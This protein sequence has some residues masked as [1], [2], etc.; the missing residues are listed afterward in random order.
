M[1]P[2]LTSTAPPL[3]NRWTRVEPQG[4]RLGSFV[5]LGEPEGLGEVAG[6]AGCELLRSDL[7]EALPVEGGHEPDSLLHNSVLRV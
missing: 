4:F 6:V 3:P 5:A 1:V 2:S 7:V